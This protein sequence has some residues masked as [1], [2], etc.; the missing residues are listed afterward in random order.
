MAYN[1]AACRSPSAWAS[2]SPRKPVEIAAKKKTG[3]FAVTATGRGALSVRGA[4]FFTTVARAAIVNKMQR[5]PDQNKRI[6]KLVGQLAEATGLG[7]ERA[8]EIMRDHCEQVTGQ[9][10]TRSLTV[11]QADDLIRRLEDIGWKFLGV[12]NKVPY[13]KKPSKEARQVHD[14]EA[15]ATPQM[16]GMLRDLFTDLGWGNKAQQRGFYK[17]VLGKDTIG[18][19][20]RGD[21][22]KVIEGLKAMWLRKN[23]HEIARAHLAVAELHQ[24]GT[25]LTPWERDFVEDVRKQIKTGKKLTPQIILKTLE[26]HDKRVAGTTKDT[27]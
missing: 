6:W 10:S 13:K 19:V 23:R 15:L 27:A 18:P 25:G 16:E 17:R 14:G 5:T 11:S 8:E 22:L 1:A 20:T 26:I 24:N 4:A 21:H 3:G 2:A 9:T 7:R 12:A